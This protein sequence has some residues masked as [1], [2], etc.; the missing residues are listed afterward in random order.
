VAEIDVSSYLNRDSI[1]LIT[2][3]GCVILWGRAPGEE[4]GGEVS[5]EQKLS[6]LD[7]HHEH[8]GHIDRGFLQEI[9]I[10]GDVVIGR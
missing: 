8:Y 10:T 3:R 7:Y 6:Y 9:D 4:R 2:D 1:R 5:A